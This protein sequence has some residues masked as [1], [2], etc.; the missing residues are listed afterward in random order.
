MDGRKI[1]ARFG[2]RGIRYWDWNAIASYAIIAMVLV[3]FIG[4]MWS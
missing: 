4:M 1:M 3:V 2:G